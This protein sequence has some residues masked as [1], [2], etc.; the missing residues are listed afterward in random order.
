M[1]PGL[2][3]LQ[4]QQTTCFHSKGLGIATLVFVCNRNILNLKNPSCVSMVYTQRYFWSV[5]CTSN[6]QGPSVQ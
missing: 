4:I 3:G 1:K 5:T 6:S 2:V